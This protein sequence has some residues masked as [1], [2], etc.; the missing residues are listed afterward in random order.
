MHPRGSQ[1]QVLPATSN[2]CLVP[3]RPRLAVASLAM[4]LWARLLAA[5]GYH[6]VCAAAIP[7]LPMSAS[8]STSTLHRQVVTPY[9]RGKAT[10]MTWR[11]TA[12]HSQDFIPANGTHRTNGTHW[13]SHKTQKVAVSSHHVITQGLV[14]GGPCLVTLSLDN[15]W[16]NLTPPQ[17][18]IL[19]PVVMYAASFLLSHTVQV[20]SGHSQTQLTHAVWVTSGHL[21]I[22]ICTTPG[23]HT[24]HWQVNR[25][26][27][28][29]PVGAAA[30]SAQCAGGAAAAAHQG[31]GGSYCSSSCSPRTVVQF[32]SES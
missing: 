16:L 25:R 11:L 20:T 24:S 22:E 17:A 4:C 23:V 19:L 10:C 6:N 21:Q 2:V 7:F 5:H 29:G 30:G 1:S 28:A 12:L 31:C 18:L 32:Q 26:N 8:T 3:W 27:P 15:E 14:K 13:K 9:R